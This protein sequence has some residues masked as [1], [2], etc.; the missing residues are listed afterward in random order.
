MQSFETNDIIDFEKKGLKSIS[1][2]PMRLCHWNNS[3][4]SRVFGHMPETN[5]AT[6]KMPVTVFFL[7]SCVDVNFEIRPFIRKLEAISKQ[8]LFNF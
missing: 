4:E 2:E 8:Q 3:F 5:A 6:K 1:S 7:R